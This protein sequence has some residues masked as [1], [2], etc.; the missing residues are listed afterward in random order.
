MRRGEAAGRLILLLAVTAVIA[1]IVGGMM[2]IDSPAKE[3]AKKLDKRRVSDLAEIALTIDRY[4]ERYHKLPA[5]MNTLQE[6]VVSEIEIADP[7]TL[8]S[9]GYHI[10]ASSAYELCAEFDTKQSKESWMYRAGRERD[11]SHNAGEYCF[12]LTP[13]EK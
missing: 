13:Y 3:R 5:D 4:W 12:R 7:K 10:T 9:Y 11:W 1:A 2:L 8:K 6:G